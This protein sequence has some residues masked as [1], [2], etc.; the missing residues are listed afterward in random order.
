[1]PTNLIAGTW[2]L[3]HCCKA[4]HLKQK[5]SIANKQ[6]HWQVLLLPVPPTMCACVCLIVLQLRSSRSRICVLGCQLALRQVIGTHLSDTATAVACLLAQ[7]QHCSIRSPTAAVGADLLLLVQSPATS[8]SVGWRST[9]RSS[10][11]VHHSASCRLAACG[12][13]CG[14]GKTCGG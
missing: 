1:M 8:S 10:C 2:V 13:C 12:P 5:S 4:K 9:R 6:Q 3:W 11:H 14:S 7:G